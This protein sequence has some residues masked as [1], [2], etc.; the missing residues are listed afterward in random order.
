[1]L[2]LPEYGWTTF[3]IG[4]AKYSLSYLT[5]IPIEWLKAVIYGLKNYSSF[6]VYGDCE[7]TD[8]YCTVTEMFCHVIYSGYKME[9]ETFFVNMTMLDFCKELHADIS[10]DV[11][12]W[13][14]WLRY[15]DE[16]FRRAHKRKIQSLLDEL[17]ALISDY[18]KKFSRRH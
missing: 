1:M 14:D 10:R 7:T 8:I 6:T 5:D 13:S 18:D 16:L 3:S 2:S 15:D 17:G 11:D 4:D 9:P 12:A